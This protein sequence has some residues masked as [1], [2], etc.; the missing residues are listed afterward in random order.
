MSNKNWIPEIL[1][2]DAG[3]EDCL[4]SNIPFIPVPD[5]EQ[6]PLL[7]YIFESRE[8]GEYEPGPEGEELPVT[9]MELH[10]YADMAALKRK[11]DLNT[12]DIVRAALGLE[13]LNSAVDKG[14]DIT[15]NIRQKLG[16]PIELKPGTKFYFGP[17]DDSKLTK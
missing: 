13:P 5:D 7:L 1:Y 12:Y 11:L 15:N 17:A 10:Q 6:M 8:T 4:T 9:E 2:E 14:R 16:Q 3:E